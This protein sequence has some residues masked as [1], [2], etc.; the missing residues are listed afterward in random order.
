MIKFSG[1]QFGLIKFNIP[2][3]SDS[4]IS[5]KCIDLNSH[6]CILEDVEKKVQ[7]NIVCKNKNLEITQMPIKERILK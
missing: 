7:S 1:N 3:F 6:I 4:A 5:L 2:I